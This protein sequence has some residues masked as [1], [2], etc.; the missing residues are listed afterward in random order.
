MPLVADS[1]RSLMAGLVVAAIVV[2]GLVLGREVLI[3]F[4]IA[5]ILS[6][7]L[8]P[9]AR[10]LSLRSLPYTIAVTAV[11]AGLIV[12]I[13]AFSIIL[14][15]QLLSL[16]AGLSSYRANMIEK[17]RILRGIGSGE[18][19]IKQAVDT[20]DK[21]GREIGE[22]L[23]KPA[24]PPTAEQVVV[25]SATKTGGIIEYVASVI[26]PA[27]QIGL[28]LLFTLFLLLQHQDLRD[29]LVK[30]AGTDNLSD[31]TAA[32]S[33]AGT[34]LSQ[35]FLAQAMLNG[36]FGVFIGLALW[37]IGVPNPIL[38]GITAAIMRFVPFIGSFIAAVPPIFLAACVDPGWGM[39]IATLLLFLVSEPVMGHLIEPIWLGSKAGLSPF[40]MVA[41]ASFWTLLWGPVGLILAAPITMVIVVLGRYIGG[42]EFVSILLGDEPALAPEQELYHR[43]L[44]GDSVAAADQIEEAMETASL[45]EV[46]DAIVLPA[47]RLAA[48]DQRRSKL[49]RQQAAELTTT[50][51]DISGLVTDAA[52]KPEAAPAGNAAPVLVVAARGA[53]DAAAAEYIAQIVPA[54]TGC[55]SQAI[56]H[57]TGLTAL[58]DFSTSSEA[59]PN[60][61]ILATVGGIEQQ[62]LRF[63]VRRAARDFPKS[64]ILV[65]DSGGA[66]PSADD[67]A[68]EDA[69]GDVTYCSSAAEMLSQIACVVPGAR[70]ERALAAATLREDL[71]TT[72]VASI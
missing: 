11:F 44:I 6:F 52:R 50:L 51:R 26:A 63:I 13:L 31:T 12:L 14:S 57:T 20:V 64:R 24:S 19:V 17:A 25:S 47:L 53:V 37:A 39:A 48:L 41:A 15:G 35:L 28:A 21:L 72:G 8:Q 33:D 32:M 7:I 55:P 70:G 9:L 54:A 66:I 45:G 30:V 62:H 40:A 36:G 22:E 27:A 4:A 49:D 58:S 3:P 67:R 18:G 65:L 43:I 38:W 56:T 16:T 42:L 10:W 5:T 69:L 61:L 23:S 1:I 68:K 29:R 46:T 34:R 2:A 59:P 60:T 71:E